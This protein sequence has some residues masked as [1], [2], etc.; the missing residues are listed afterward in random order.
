MALSISML[1]FNTSPEI[2]SSCQIEMLCCVHLTT[3]H[4]HLSTGRTWQRSCFW[5]NP[6]CRSVNLK[7]FWTMHF[8]LELRQFFVV[9]IKWV[10]VQ[11]LFYNGKQ[12]LSLRIFQ[13]WKW[14]KYPATYSSFPL[15]EE[16]QNLNW[17]KG[18]E[19]ATFPN[20]NAKIQCI[21]SIEYYKYVHIK[22]TCIVIY[23]VINIYLPIQAILEYF[24]VE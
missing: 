15:C 10:C 16:A 14:N 21:Y 23:A 8:A 24:S 7:H 19:Q 20:L 1:V 9:I 22:N 13:R 17:K 5:Q 2:F 18:K 12:T 11:C 4:S 6:K 3:P